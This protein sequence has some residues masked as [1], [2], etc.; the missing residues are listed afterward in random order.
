MVVGDGLVEPARVAPIYA[1]CRDRRDETSRKKRRET[2]RFPQPERC[3]AEGTEEEEGRGAQCRKSFI[4]PLTTGP[5]AG[6]HSAESHRPPAVDAVVLAGL[7]E[8]ARASCEQLHHGCLCRA[9][10]ATQT[11]ECLPLRRGQLRA[12]DQHHHGGAKNTHLQGTRRDS[13]ARVLPTA[14]TIGNHKLKWKYE[15]SQLEMGETSNSRLEKTHGS[16]RTLSSCARIQHHGASITT[17]I[18]NP[19]QHP[20]VSVPLRSTTGVN[21][22]TADAIPFILTAD[23]TYKQLLKTTASWKR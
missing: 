11:R 5:S 6:P 15:H 12:D 10:R 19:P 20:L 18:K 2:K 1:C 21:A 14:R 7:S 22:K 3:D 4:K 17:K 9:L 13:L 8:S 16:T 23:D